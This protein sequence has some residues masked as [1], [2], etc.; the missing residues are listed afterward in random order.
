MRHLELLAEPP[1][2]PRLQLPQLQQPARRGLGRDQRGL[3]RLPAALLP[4]AHGLAAEQPEPA[5]QPAVAGA[6]ADVQPAAGQPG[7]AA[8]AAL[9]GARPRLR[10]R[11][12]RHIPHGGAAADAGQREP[13]QSGEAQAGHSSV[14]YN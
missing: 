8:A 10:P 1:R 12:L 6:A 4:A 11:P 7:L 3:A 2:R 9:A 5:E 13:A 14:R